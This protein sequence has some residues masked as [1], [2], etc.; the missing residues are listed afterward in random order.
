MV[1]KLLAIGLVVAA[2]G[3]AAC[4]GHGS[5][6]GTNGVDVVMLP[7][8]DPDLVM[9]ATVPK[10][11]IGEELP[12][13]GLGTIKSA[14]W[15]AVVGGFTQT[16]YSQVLGFKPHTKITILNLSHSI[17]HT[18]DVVKAVKGPPANFPANPVLSIKAKGGSEL[19][20]G[21]ASGPIKPGKSVT[22]SLDTE[23]IFLIGCAFHYHSGMRDVLV[24]NPEAARGKQATPPPR[25]TAT[26]TSRSSYEP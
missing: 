22:V 18:L 19:K 23:G 14:K 26:P 7:Q 17:T 21:Y 8:V 25:A 10:D 15:Q 3:A 20:T 1:R 12:S 4:A 11:T 13:E 6:G 2:L 9:F 5:S 16:R 24:V